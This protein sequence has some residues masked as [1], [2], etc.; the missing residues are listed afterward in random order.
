MTCTDSLAPG[1]ADSVTA[2]CTGAAGQGEQSAPH[3]PRRHGKSGARPPVDPFRKR[4]LACIREGRVSVVFVKSESDE[5]VTTW[6]Q[7]VPTAVLAR[8]LSSRD[9]HPYRVK[10]EG[11]FVGG[12]WSCDCREGRRDLPCAHTLAVALVTTGV[13]S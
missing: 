4:A 8:V 11:S 9:R 10:F 3:G 6:Q 2:A 1:T 7:V 13:P 12:A 5:R